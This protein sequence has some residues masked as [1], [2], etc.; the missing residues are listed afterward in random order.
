M[1]TQSDQRKSVRIVA[2]SSKSVQTLRTVNIVATAPADPHHSVKEHTQLTAAQ[3]MVGIHPTWMDSGG[4][5]KGLPTV[6]IN[7]YTGPS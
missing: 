3:T 1:S 5:V 6:Y 4:S 2:F 7:G